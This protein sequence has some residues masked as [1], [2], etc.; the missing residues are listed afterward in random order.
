MHPSFGYG[1]LPDEFQQEDTAKIIIV[2][3]AYDDTSTWIKGADRG[4]AALIEASANME[5]YD[6][7]TDSEVYKKGIYT[8]AALQGFPDPDQMVH[9]VKETVDRYITQNK[10]VAV[11]GGEHSVSIGAIQ[12]HVERFQNCSVL[13]LDAHTDLRDS[14]EGSKFN[15]ACVMAR[16][17]EICPIVQVGIRSMDSS[18][19]QLVEKNRVIFAEQMQ[20]HS[21]WIAA[22]P[23]LLTDNVYITLD[24]DVFDSSIMPS[25]GTPE[26]GGLGWYDALNILKQVAKTKNIIGLDMVELCPNEQNKAPDFLAAKLL[27]KIVT[28]KYTWGK[29]E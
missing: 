4:P 18:E 16:T 9:A 27:Y 24:L 2:P 26:P 6:I 21:D 15:H 25:T 8:T 29:H 12:A 14:Y 20:G 11:L 5:L 17:Q 13:Q 23:P 3:V 19:L 28:Y 10:F 22:I 7:E 1:N